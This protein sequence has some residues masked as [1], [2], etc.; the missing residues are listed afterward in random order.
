MSTKYTATYNLP[1]FHLWEKLWGKR[2]PMAFDLEITARCNNNCLH[3]Y[4]N[5]PAQ[6]EEA[7][8]RE[9]TLTEIV[10][11]GRQAVEMGAVWCLLTGGEPLLREDFADIYIALKRL[12][13]LVSIFTNACLITSEHIKLLKKYPPRDLEVTV[14]GV[15]RDIYEGV[16]RSNGSFAAFTRG[17][18]LLWNSGLPMRLKAMVM[19]AN[20]VEFPQIASFCQERTK[21]YFRFDPFLHL[22]FDKDLRRNE[23]IKAQRLTPQEIAA[24]EIAN[25]K[26]WYAIQKEC[27]RL[28]GKAPGQS[29]RGHLFHCGVGLGSFTVS[30]E[31]YFRLCSSL[32]HPDCV[33]DLRLGNL[34][35]AWEDFALQV[36]GVHSQAPDYLERCG[37]CHLVNLCPWCPANAYLETGRMDAWVEYF[38]HVT[39]ARAQ[40]LLT[41]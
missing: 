1:N 26:R 19:R 14:Y 21:D 9:L 18:D 11:L 13:L 20:L 37:Q 33:Y 28:V 22:R 12:G 38:C 39:K 5:L 27:D 32:W 40:N 34:S 4:I 31:G 23:E 16:T 24:I 17:L 15:T 7:K 8:S 10:D 25:P 35:Q 29:S 6:D 2:R 41:I 36:R 30:P 3:C